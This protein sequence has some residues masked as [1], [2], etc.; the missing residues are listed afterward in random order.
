MPKRLVENFL[1][2]ELTYKIR[3]AIFNVYNTLGYGHRESVYQNALAKEFKKQEIPFEREKSLPV[4]YDGEKVGTYRPDFVV[5]GKIILEL[6]AAPFIGKGFEKQ[7]I[8]YLKG[9]DF[10]LGLLV[11][12]GAN[13]LQIKRRIW[14]VD[15][16]RKSAKNRCKS[17]D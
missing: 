13:K 16:Q 12:F 14:D 2:E 1:Y 9:T 8:Y 17:G 11:N 4:L 15:H 7:L 10:K 5:D 3:R 6:K